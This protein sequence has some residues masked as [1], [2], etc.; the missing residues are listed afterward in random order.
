MTKPDKVELGLFDQIQRAKYE[1]EITADALSQFVCLIDKD[2]TVQRANRAVETWELADVKQVK[3]KSLHNLFHPDCDQGESCYLHKFLS[4]LW[5]TLEKENAAQCEAEDKVLHR[6]LSFRV[7]PI[8]AKNTNTIQSAALVV[9]DISERK[10]LERERGHL[11]QQVEE[12]AQLLNTIL[13]NTPDQIY[14]YDNKMTCVYAN[15]AAQWHLGLSED[16]IVG[17][18]WTELGFPQAEE[19]TFNQMC[20]RVLTDKQRLKNELVQQ[21]GTDATNYF[22]YIVSPVSGMPD[23]PSSV[24]VTFRDVTERVVAKREIQAAHDH[25][26]QRVAE[27]TVELSTANNLLEEEIR[28]RQRAEESERQQ[29]AVAEILHGI[30]LALTRTLDL[31]TMLETVVNYIKRVVPFEAAYI[32]MRDGDS[33]I[34]QVVYPTDNMNQ[35]IPNLAD[36]AIVQRIMATG[37]SLLIADTKQHSD[38]LPHTISDFEGRSLLA[39]PMI[40]GETI[41]GICVMEHSD[42]NA[43]TTEHERFAKVCAVQAA[44]ALD[45]ARLFAEADNGRSRLQALSRRLVDVQ[46]QERRHLALELHDQIGQ[47][48]TGLRFTIENTMNLPDELVKDN[49]KFAQ[50][51]IKELTSQVRELSLN[52]RPSM[53]DDLGLLPTLLWHTARYTDGTEI[54]VNFKHVGLNDKRFDSNIEITVYRVVQEALTNVA[55]YAGVKEVTVRIYVNEEALQ[56]E[57]SDSGKGFDTKSIF[58]EKHSTGLTG[59][60]ERVAVLSGT[61]VLESALNEGTHISAK[62]PL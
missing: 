27:R 48:L 60:Q 38:P 9:D 57:I 30:T 50:H 20:K 6:D 52:L 28:E 39:I 15:L 44:F 7:R 23:A 34:V 29:R 51:Q 36:Y 10:A 21:R 1:W 25:L 43:F 56:L 5:T 40:G 11:L 45:N 41:I 54:A 49:M 13:S 61:F 3:G 4:T 14:M 2:L 31:N 46:E 58:K 37:K 47:V 32:L 53:L 24:V 26:E 22:E 18:T 42:L 8:I 33:D 16:E 17:K 35:D 19:A 62:L 55:R 59:M 12:Q